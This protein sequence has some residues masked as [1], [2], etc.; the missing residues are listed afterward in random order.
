MTKREG[1]I[2]SAYTGVLL[3]N[4]LHEYHK[5]IEEILKRPI[6]THEI[7]YLA[8]EIKLKATNDFNTVIESQ[9]I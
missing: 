9:K 1:A 3:C 6:Y 8:D 5:Y 4:D 2:L 7:P